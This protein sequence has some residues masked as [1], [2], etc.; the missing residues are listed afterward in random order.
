V[1]WEQLSSRLGEIIGR[2]GD[3]L[4]RVKGVIRTIGDQRPL[5]IHGVQR[6]FHGPARLDRWTR[7]PATSI[8]V[9]GDKDSG[10]AIELIA[11]A[12]ADAADPV[13]ASLVQPGPTFAT[14]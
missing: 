9:I 14:A 2:Y 8:V 11:A 1:D 4:L 6:V 3:R 5:V 7:Q 13:S 12:L 10:P